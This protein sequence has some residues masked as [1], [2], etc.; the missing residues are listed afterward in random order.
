MLFEINRSNI[1]LYCRNW[2]EM[3]QFYRDRLGLPIN[4][5]DDWFIEF[6]LNDNTFISVA[7]ESR[8][9]IKSAAGQG[10]TLTWQV[11]N[12]VEAR[13]ALIAQGI[14]VTEIKHRWGAKVCYLHDPEC[15]RI[16][17]WQAAE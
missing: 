8:T 11:A 7:D 16:E 1:I 17:L 14:D 9:S 15:N 13:A 5:Q 2:P 4:H 10:I 12:V 6:Q 3:V